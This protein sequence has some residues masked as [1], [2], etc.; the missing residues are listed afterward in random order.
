VNIKCCGRDIRNPWAHVPPS[1]TATC[2]LCPVS[3]KAERNNYM[4][5]EA[6]IGVA[7]IYTYRIAA[8]WPKAAIQHAPVKL[9]LRR[10]V[11]PLERNESVP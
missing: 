5:P 6:A 9:Y 4:W 10:I 8:L 2:Q 3:R 11:L 1:L 7:E